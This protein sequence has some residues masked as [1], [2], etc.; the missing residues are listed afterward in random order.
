VLDDLKMIHQRDT[1]DALG[2][3]EKQWLQNGAGFLRTEVQAWLPT[4]PTK[5]NIAKQIALESIGK[6]VVI[7][8]SPLL[9][10]AAQHWKEGF[11]E[12]ARQLAWVGDLTPTELV[13]WTKQPTIKLYAVI[14]LISELEPA[15]VQKMFEQSAR[16]LSGLR[17]EPVRVYATGK[18]PEEQLLW[19]LNLGDF[20]TIYTGLL[21]GVNPRPVELVE[22]F[23]K[24]MEE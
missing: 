13:G 17:P 24:M 7:Y 9:T 20:V 16:Q 23:K 18:T 21:N 6:S 5:H 22:K 15:H 11:N 19:A 3:A 8:G 10:R 2:Q 12:H 4:V 1:H 14:E